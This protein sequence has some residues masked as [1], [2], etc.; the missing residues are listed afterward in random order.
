MSN[1]NFGKVIWPLMGLFIVV[2]WP[3]MFYFSGLWSFDGK[4]WNISLL[5]TLIALPV[6]LYIIFTLAVYMREGKRRKY[7]RLLAVI[8]VLFLF[9]DIVSWGNLYSWF[10]TP[11]SFF[12][13][14]ITT[15]ITI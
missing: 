7:L 2:I 1:L 6:S 14:S 15:Q 5:H 9:V 8:F 10:V 13:E 3:A 11:I 12:Y 4:T